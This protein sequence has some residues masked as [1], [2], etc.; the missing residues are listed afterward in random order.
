MI[1]PSVGTVWPSRTITMSSMRRSAASI[2]ISSPSRITLAFRG[3]RSTSPEMA[4]MVRPLARASR[5]LPTEISVGIITVA[6]K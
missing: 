1:T 6:S 3:A 5:Y 4:S 2:S